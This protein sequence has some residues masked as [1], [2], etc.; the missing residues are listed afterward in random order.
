[1][2]SGLGRSRRPRRRFPIA[3]LSRATTTAQWQKKLDAQIMA[4]LVERIEINCDMG[5]GFGRWKMVRS[6]LHSSPKPK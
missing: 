2:T 5:E 1:V 4:G 6:F 3:E